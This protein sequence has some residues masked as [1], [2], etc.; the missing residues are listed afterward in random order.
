M[1]PT[2]TLH[3][4]WDL[5][6][7]GKGQG[8]CYSLVCVLWVEVVEV[9]CYCRLMIRFSGYEIPPQ[10][11]TKHCT[12]FS[13]LTASMDLIWHHHWPVCLTPSQMIDVRQNS[14]YQRTKSRQM[15]VIWWCTLD[16][17]FSDDCRGKKKTEVLHH[18]TCSWAIK[19]KTVFKLLFFW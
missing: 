13:C 16:E 1:V 9:G 10:S 11:I 17:V 12:M 14:I 15:Y 18:L 4:T 19:C 2:S 5:T 6:C 8:N 7:P 3:V